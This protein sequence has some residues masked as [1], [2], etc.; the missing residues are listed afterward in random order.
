[1][2]LSA[3]CLWASVD[4]LK[5]W[6]K[7][8]VGR[9]IE[10]DVVLAQLAESVTEEFERLTGRVWVSRTFTRTFDGPGTPWL[11]LQAYPVTS[12]LTSF[13]QDGTAVATTVY[14][15]DTVNGY[16]KRKSGVWTAGVGNFAVAYTAGYARASLPK[17]VVQLAA[18]MVR[19]R[20]T[21]WTANADHVSTLTAYG[22]QYIPR[23]SW[24]YHV[25]DGLQ[26]LRDERGARIGV[27]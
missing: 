2:A 16:V 27:A 25:K 21:D 14:V 17:N 3:T 15:L 12:P 19:W 8:A 11:D 5:P 10:D 6:L 13:T 7:L 4:D 18:E 20:Y 26:A 24:P 23:S 1:M 9:D 22:S